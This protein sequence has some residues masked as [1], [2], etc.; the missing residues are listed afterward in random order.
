MPAPREDARTDRNRLDK[1]YPEPLA[2][3]QEREERERAKVRRYLEGLDWSCG[4]GRRRFSGLAYAA[5][6]SLAI[7]SRSCRAGGL[8]RGGR[9]AGGAAWG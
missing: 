8:G 3:V 2:G 1:L 7:I 4:F 6:P 5:G 9:L